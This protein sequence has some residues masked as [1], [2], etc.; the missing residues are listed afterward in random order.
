VV[1]TLAIIIARWKGGLGGMN[2]VLQEFF[3]S[4]SKLNAMKIVLIHLLAQ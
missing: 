3:S 2:I 1:V 4:K